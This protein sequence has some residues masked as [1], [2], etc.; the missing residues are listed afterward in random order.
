MILLADGYG[1]ISSGNF[2]PGNGPFDVAVVG[3]G[4]AGLTAANVLVAAGKRVVV[5]EARTRI[6]GRAFTE[7][8]FV[9]PVDLGDQFFHQSLVNPLIQIAKRRRFQTVPDISPREIYAGS[10]PVDPVTNPGAIAAIAQFIAMLK[11]ADDAGARIAA[12]EQP[13]ESV[14]AAMGS[15]VGQPW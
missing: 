8:N 3:A 12:G 1:G 10:T 7:N 5:L 15:L 14:A 9:V 6:G 4:L 13:D 2:S 11:A